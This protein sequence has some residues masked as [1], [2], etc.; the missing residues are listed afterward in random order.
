[1]L[2]CSSY[3]WFKDHHSVWVVSLSSKYCIICCIVLSMFFTDHHSVWVI[4]LTISLNPLFFSAMLSSCWAWFFDIYF[5][6]KLSA[7]ISDLYTLIIENSWL[8]F[9][10]LKMFSFYFIFKSKALFNEYDNF[11]ASQLKWLL[12]FGTEYT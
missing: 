2:Q 5:M 12:K 1:M 4:S 7:S 8:N 3:S 6:Y 11:F 9:S 10:N